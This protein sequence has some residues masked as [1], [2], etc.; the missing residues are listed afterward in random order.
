MNYPQLHA[1]GSMI[2]IDRLTP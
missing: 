1:H 2:F